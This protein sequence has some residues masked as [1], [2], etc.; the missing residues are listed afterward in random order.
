[1]REQ[2]QK[3]L[4][5]DLSSLHIAKQTDVEQSTVYRLRK[6]ERSLD[7]LG[8]GKAEKLYEF[9]NELFNSEDDE[10]QHLLVKRASIMGMLA[11]LEM[12][13]EESDKL[14]QELHDI[15][16][17]LEDIQKRQIISDVDIKDG[18]LLVAAYKVGEKILFHQKELNQELKQK[19][20]NKNDYFNKAL[21]E[22]KNDLV[23]DSVAI[24]WLKD[25]DVSNIRLYLDT[26]YEKF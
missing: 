12:T 1:M 17:R 5:S 23:Y 10:K 9:A 2:I 22:V 8:L 4:D 18:F 25:K 24:E 20:M 14:N 13:D 19:R 21:T 15:E 16:G 3:L 6:G 26:F 11:N 7:K